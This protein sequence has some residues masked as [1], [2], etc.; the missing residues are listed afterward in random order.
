MRL[1]A[2]ETTSGD[3]YPAGIPSTINTRT[4][5]NMSDTTAASIAIDGQQYDINSLSDEARSQIT[6]LQVVD[7]KIAEAQQTLAILHTARIAYAGALKAALPA[8]DQ[9]ADG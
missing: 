6:N 8:S 7:Q 4:V 3:N 5:T 1:G 2:M 9:Q